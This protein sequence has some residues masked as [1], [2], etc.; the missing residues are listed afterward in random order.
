MNPDFYINITGA[1]QSLIDG[2]YFYHAPN[3]Y[4]HKNG[5]FKII[6][7]QLQFTNCKMWGI[8]EINDPLNYD[9]NTICPLYTLHAS[10]LFSNQPWKCVFGQLPEPLLKK[11]NLTQKLDHT[12]TETMDVDII[13]SMEQLKINTDKKSKSYKDCHQHNSSS[14]VP[15]LFITTFHSSS[16]PPL[17]SRTFHSSSVSSLKAK[18][19]SNKTTGRKRLKYDDFDSDNDTQMQPGQKRRK[20]FNGNPQKSK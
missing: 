12:S 15:P 6:K 3:E 18:K 5:K 8:I 4:M 14:S 19:K 20:L 16:V 11:V 17:F 2:N 13:S 7:V 1:G 9:D 10:S